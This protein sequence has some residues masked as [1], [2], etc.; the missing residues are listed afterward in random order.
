LKSIT[1]KETMLIVGVAIG[2][3]IMMYSWGFTNFWMLFVGFNSGAGAGVVVSMIN[4]AM[5]LKNA[6]AR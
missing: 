6:I 2:G 1:K 3:V 5:K 4:R